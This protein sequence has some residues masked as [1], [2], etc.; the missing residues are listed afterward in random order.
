MEKIKERL[1]LCL[2]ALRRLVTAQR[3]RLDRHALRD[4]GLESYQP[5]LAQQ[6]LEERRRNLP[7][8][9]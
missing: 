1:L 6:M 2:D 8:L 5:G 3:A 9:L 4:I 7:G